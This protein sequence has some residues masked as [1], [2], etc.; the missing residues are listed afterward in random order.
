L[1]KTIF[2]TQNFHLNNRNKKG[3]PD[4]LMVPSFPSAVK[5]RSAVGTVIEGVNELAGKQT[6]LLSRGGVDA[7]VIKWREAHS[8]R[9]RGGAGQSTL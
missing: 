1:N 8:R 2:K 6:P 3:S 4:Q 7:A 5:F 9:R